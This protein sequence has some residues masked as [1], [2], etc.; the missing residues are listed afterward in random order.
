[1]LRLNELGLLL[2]ILLP[3]AYYVAARLYL[4]P[5]RDRSLTR[6]ELA[7]AAVVGVAVVVFF[8]AR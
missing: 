4:R 6:V 1:V 7:L 5:G 2:G 3:V 8:A